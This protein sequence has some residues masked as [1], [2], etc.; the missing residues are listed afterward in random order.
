MTGELLNELKRY[1]PANYIRH[2]S[3]NDL[4]SDPDAS[5]VLKAV[6]KVADPNALN[7]VYRNVFDAC[8]MVTKYVFDGLGDG[9]NEL[10]EFITGFENIG[11]ELYVFFLVRFDL[12]LVR[13]NLIEVTEY[14]SMTVPDTWITNTFWTC[15]RKYVAM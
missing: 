14:G 3:V 8:T 11:M 6:R 7:T 4:V 2:V 1:A 13:L 15:F 10:K 5:E 12:M 9:F